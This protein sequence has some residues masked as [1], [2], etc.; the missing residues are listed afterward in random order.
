MHPSVP[1][2]EETARAPGR[3][4]SCVCP[5]HADRVVCADLRYYGHSPAQTHLPREERYEC[6]CVCH[7]EAEQAEGGEL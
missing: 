6:E 5:E 2:S 4:R 7:G 1:P 3:D